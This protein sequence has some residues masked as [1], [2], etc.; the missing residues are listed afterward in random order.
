[1]LL[2][3]EDLTV[4]YSCF[5]ALRGITLHVDKGECVALLGAN[6][7]GKTTLTKAMLHMVNIVDGKIRFEHRRIDHLRTNEIVNLGISVCP[8]KGGCF[9]DL[10]VN[11]NLLL[12]SVTLK[13]R[14]MIESCYDRCIK[15]FPILETRKN[16]K[17]G[18]LSGGERQMLAIGRAL[19]A[20]PKLLV[21]DEPSL[22]LAPLVVNSILESIE[23]LRSVGLAILLI[24]Q[25]AA[26][27]LKIAQRGYIME[28]GTIILSGDSKELLHN[29]MIR[30]AY[31]GI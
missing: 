15:L 13:D 18:S 3:V 2:H 19:M 11:K 26:K 5:K 24:E 27:S 7:S 8:E 9:P 25:N 28:L 29:E 12:G 20:N 6:G 14:S 16:Q 31:I 4:E 17:A 1:M 23:K 21:L 30:K 22:G 10:T